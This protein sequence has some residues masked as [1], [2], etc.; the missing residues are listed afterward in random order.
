MNTA[1]LDAYWEQTNSIPQLVYDRV[2][3]FAG[4]PVNMFKEDGKWVSI[5]YYEFSVIAENVALG[6]MK[7]G[8]KAGD[9]AGIKAATGAYWTW[10]D[11]GIIFAGCASVSLYPT[12]EQP[13][14]VFIANHSKMK[15]CFA[16]TKT[17]LFDMLRYSDKMPGVKYYICLEKGFT[18]DG[19]TVFGLDEL[20]A[21]GDAARGELYEEMKARQAALTKESPLSM[22]YTSGTTGALKGAMVSHGGVMHAAYGGYKHMAQYGSPMDYNL[23]TICVLPLSHILAKVD[24]YYGPLVNGGMIGFS[25][26][27]TILADFQ[28][29]RPTWAMFVPRLLS[30]VYLGMQ[31]IAAATEAG[32]GAWDWAMDIATKTTYALEDENGLIDT[33]TPYPEQL[34]KK[35]PEL[36]AMWEAAYNGVFYRLHQVFGGQLKDLCVGGAYL[37]PELARKF[38]GMGFRLTNGYGLT[39]TASGLFHTRPNA[40]KIGSVGPCFD[41][42]DVKL[43][44]DGEILIKRGWCVIDKY[45]DNEEASKEAFTPDGYFRTGD[46]GVFDDFGNLS[47]VD[48]KKSIIVLDTGKNV[49]GAKVEGVCSMYG[50]LD[51]VAVMGQ[52]KPFVSALIVP[53]L[54]A[55]IAKMTE[56]GMDFDHDGVVY[57]EM[58][59]M[60]AIL[61]VPQSVVDGDVVTFLVKDAIEKVNAQ[62]EAHEQ[63]KGYRI[64]NKKFTEENGMMTPSTKLKMK[65]IQAAYQDVYDDIYKK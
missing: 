49:A 15:A 65:N 11:M 56:A 4:R 6:L 23:R 36:K 12:L 39:E 44:E 55:I 42:A 18:G 41:D 3:T 9:L 51:Q 20:M 35:D 37:D 62:L 45:W 7:L 33:T 25:S 58:N 13:D 1:M 40:V 31:Q 48:R 5:T 10:A 63:I 28:A 47:I 53:N 32:K 43:D 16:G 30:R 64:L 57:G 26:P 27:A 50:I 59:G 38:I 2:A 52:D 34:E 21:L 54:D 17:I 24:D 29:I 22:V 46:I 8:F 19:K 14:T 61:E 60:P